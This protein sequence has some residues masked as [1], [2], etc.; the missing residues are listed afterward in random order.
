MCLGSSKAVSPR[1]GLFKR[2]ISND[3]FSSSFCERRG[4]F[5]PAFAVRSWSSSWMKNSLSV[6]VFLWADSSGLLIPRVFPHWPSRILW[7]TVEVFMLWHWSL[8]RYLLWW[9]IINCIFLSD[10]SEQERKK[11]ERKKE[12]KKKK[13]RKRERE[14]ERKGEREKGRKRERK[15]ERERKKRNVR[16]STQTI[17]ASQKIP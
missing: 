14:K 11:K 13:E 5:S 8:W 16:N 4:N 3:Y 15:R 6:G 9:V 10:S 17:N 7:V 1:A 2:I 12:R